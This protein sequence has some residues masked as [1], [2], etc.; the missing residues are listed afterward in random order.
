[1]QPLQRFV[2]VVDQDGFGQLQFE[3]R[4]RDAADGH[5]TG[6]PIDKV[7]LLELHR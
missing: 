7:R 3:Q 2:G 6:H 4:R 1:M 5:H